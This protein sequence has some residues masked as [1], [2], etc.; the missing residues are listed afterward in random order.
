VNTVKMTAW[1]AARVALTHEQAAQIAQLGLVDVAAEPGSDRWRLTSG[2]KI[3]VAAGEDWELRVRPKIDVPKLFFLLAYGRDPAGWRS[4]VA[5]F[6]PEPEFVDAIASAFSMHA[7][8]ALEQGVLRGYVH[9]EERSAY[10]RGRIRFSDQIAAG[11]VPLPIAIEYDDYTTDILEN[12]LLKTA[13]TLLLRLPRVPTA[14]RRRLMHLRLL[15]D[16]VDL[17]DR[18]REA[19]A[20]PIT[21]LNE[22]YLPAMRLAELV[23]RNSSLD[24]AAGSVAGIAFVFDMNDVF[25]EFVTTALGDALTAGAGRAVA[26]WSSSLDLEGGVGI[27]PDLTW[28]LGD[29]PAAVIDA[30]YKSLADASVRA[31]D[32]YQMFAYCTA[33]DLAS[34]FLVYAKD[35]DVRIQNH[36]VRN[37]GRELRV[38]TLD[39]EQEPAQLMDDVEA[40]ADEIRATVGRRRME[41]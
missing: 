4:T 5:L 34:G 7:I 17:L 11:G 27:R 12:R 18:P 29:R 36:T 10:V 16:E 20:P 23:L 35:R 37:S 22:R 30:K 15:L 19:V 21:R 3:G 1:A 31:A 13:A 9:V 25:E 24:A 40:L 2:S 28:W 33:L 6:D 41:R 14:A 32:A 8:R 26:Q 39:L 38:R